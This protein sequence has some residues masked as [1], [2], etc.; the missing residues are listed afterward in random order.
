M[1]LKN[2]TLT[3]DYSA[4]VVDTIISYLVFSEEEVLAN[5]DKDKDSDDD[6]AIAITKKAAK[7]SNEKTNALKLFVKNE[8]DTDWYQVIIKNIMRFELGMDHVSIGISFS[9][10]AAAIH[11]A[12]DISDMIGDVSVQVFSLAF[13]AS[14]HRDQSLFDFRVRI[15]YKG[16]LCII[17][18]V[19]L[20]M[21]DCHMAEI[22]YNMVVEFFDA[23]YPD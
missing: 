12:R 15:C 2:D 6:V 20:P 22:I 5:A 9:Q 4:R 8:N 17:H 13:D 14:T 3:Y 1:T 19:G 18:L 16:L 21:F 7:H 11:H 23:L 10:T